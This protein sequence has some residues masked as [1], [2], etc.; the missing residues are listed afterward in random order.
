MYIGILI[1][2]KRLQQNQAGTWHENEVVLTSMR[3]DDVASTLIRRHFGTKCPLGRCFMGEGSFQVLSS[4]KS[5]LWVGC[6]SQ[7]R[8]INS[9]S[10][11][12]KNSWI[13]KQPTSWW[14]DSWEQIYSFR[15]WPPLD[16]SK[17][18]NETVAFPKRVTTHGIKR[19]CTH[20]KSC[21]FFHYIK[22][23]YLPIL[24]DPQDEIAFF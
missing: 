22:F 21:M 19:I 4:S 16:G 24:H 6:S 12:D 18:K 2:I 14:G 13:C 11:R 5:L 8:N 17:N 3:R 10:T 7:S 23:C 9:L 15:S 1:N 20:C